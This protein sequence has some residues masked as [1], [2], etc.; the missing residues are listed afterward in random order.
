MPGFNGRLLR[1]ERLKTTTRNRYM[2]KWAD[3]TELAI[4]CETNIRLDS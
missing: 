2:I 4:L 1:L 3:G